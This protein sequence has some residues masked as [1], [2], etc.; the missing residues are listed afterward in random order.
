MSLQG[1]HVGHVTFDRTGDVHENK[2]LWK[3]F[4]SLQ[5]KQLKQTL[6]FTSLAEPKARIREGPAGPVVFRCTQCGYS[7]ATNH[8]MVTHRTRKHGV[9]CVPRHLHDGL[10]CLLCPHVGASKPAIQNHAQK[11][12]WPKLSQDL[13]DYWTERVNS[14]T[15]LQ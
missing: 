4:L 5:K 3:W 7:C 10:K 9:K 13:K 8:Q 14:G 1:D 2:D 6:T 12:C 11:V 15:H